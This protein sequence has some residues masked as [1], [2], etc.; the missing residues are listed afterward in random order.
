MRSRQFHA[1][2]SCVAFVLIAAFYSAVTHTP[3]DLL[4]V[5]CWSAAGIAAYVVLSYA[6]GFDP[7]RTRIAQYASEWVHYVDRWELR[8]GQTTLSM[9]G[10]MVVGEKLF[11]PSHFVLAVVSGTLAAWTYFAWRL[12]AGGYNSSGSARRA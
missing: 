2:L 3:V 10:C 1:T 12:Y 8:L 11:D 5:A 6:F 7:H 4:R 9:L